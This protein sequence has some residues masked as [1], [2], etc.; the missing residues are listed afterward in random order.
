MGYLKCDKCRGYYELKP[1]ES[2]DDFSE[3]ECG[4]NLEYVESLSQP[5]PS[6]QKS[7]TEKFNTSKQTKA[8]S[9]LIGS[10]K[11]RF[12]NLS[13][14]NKIFSIGG[15]LILL[16]LV[17]LFVLPSNLSAAHYDKNNVS[18]D[19]PTDWNITTVYENAQMVTGQNQTELDVSGPG[20]SVGTILITQ[21][22][23][24]KGLEIMINEF[25]QGSVEKSLNG[26][27]YYEKIS[28]G[29]TNSHNVG[30]FVK[31]N[32]ICSIKIAGKKGQVNDGFKMIINS[33]RFK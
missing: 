30:I 2:P 9:K 17:T 19:Y 3:C 21:I 14:R 7:K 23:D 1:G 25:K 11:E 31:D 5:I 24:P 29:D 20:I 28:D 33:F 8:A 18:F 27:T 6:S 26:Y 32:K 15:I 22:D 16:A 4:G 12:M 13:S 10:T